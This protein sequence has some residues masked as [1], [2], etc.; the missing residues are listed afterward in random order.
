MAGLKTGIAHEET[1]QMETHYDQEHADE[2]I[3]LANNIAA[4]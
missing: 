4:K 1:Y 2:K 3:D